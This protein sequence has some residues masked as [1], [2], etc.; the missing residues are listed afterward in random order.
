MKIFFYQSVEKW[1]EIKWNIKNLRRIWVTIY[2]IN[3]WNEL[4][5][6]NKSKLFTK[7]ECRVVS[8]FCVQDFLNLI[9]CGRMDETIVKFELT[10]SGIS[11]GKW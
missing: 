11:E 3:R 4:N 8:M 9:W 1:E 6:K 7:R 2:A 10:Q 5:K